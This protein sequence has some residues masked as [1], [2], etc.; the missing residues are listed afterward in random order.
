MIKGKDFFEALKPIRALP[1][2]TD[3]QKQRREI[4]EDQ[5]EK[6][7]V[8]TPRVRRISDRRV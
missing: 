3:E 2:E 1:S 7:P 8:L 6:A 5:L 4:L